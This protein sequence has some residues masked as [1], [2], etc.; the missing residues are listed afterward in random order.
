MKARVSVDFD[1]CESHGQCVIAA[2]E[3]FR[4]DDDGYLQHDGVVEGQ[5]ATDAEDAVF[6]CPTQAITV[7]RES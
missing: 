6:L 5:A 3:V 4:F 7:T 1:V 2:P